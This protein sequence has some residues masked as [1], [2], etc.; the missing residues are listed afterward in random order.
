MRGAKVLQVPKTSGVHFTMISDPAG[1]VWAFADTILAE[2]E[3]PKEE[4]R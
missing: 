3:E 4:R 2:E 1:F